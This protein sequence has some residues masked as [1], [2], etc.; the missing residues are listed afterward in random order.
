M[1]PLLRVNS[2]KLTKVNPEGSGGFPQLKRGR[3]ITSTQL[4]ERANELEEIHKRWNQI[5]INANPVISAY[6]S[7]IVPKSSRMKR[8]LRNDGGDADGSVVGAK[9]WSSNGRTKHQIVHCLTLGCLK[10]SIEEL[11]ATA[12]VLDRYANGYADSEFVR[13]VNLKNNRK[14]WD[15]LLSDENLSRTSFCQT[16]VDI[17]FIERFGVDNVAPDYDDEV[18]VTLYK[19]DLSMSELFEK[20][21]VTYTNL[22][23]LGKDTVVLS[24]G[25]YAK[26]KSCA[27]YLIAMSLVERT[28]MDN[29]ISSTSRFFGG[30]N[31]PAPSNEPVIGVID[32]LFDSDLENTYFSEWVEPHELVDPNIKR[33]KDSYLHGT[34]VDSIIVDGPALNP[35][36]DDGCGRFRVRHFGITADLRFSVLTFLREIEGIVRGNRDIKVWNLSLGSPLTISDNSISPVGAVL[37]KIQRECDVIFVIA[38]T[39]LPKKIAHGTEYK[40]GSPADSVN[41]MVVNAVDGEG[42]PASYSR[43]GPVLSSFTKPDIAYFGGDENEP[44]LTWAD[45]SEHYSCGTSYAAP[46]IARKLAYLTEIIGLSKEAAKALIIDSASRWEQQ[47]DSRLLGHGVVP[48]HIN[49]IL[50]CPDDEIRLIVSGVAGPNKTSNFD[51]PVPRSKGKH[52]Y[53]GK[54]TLCYFPN[55]TRQQ[56]VDYTNTEIDLKFGRIKDG[57]ISSINNDH[58]GEKFFYITEEEAR[59]YFQ[60]WDNTKI[61]R[62]SIKSRAIAKKSFPNSNWGFSL[63]A[64]KRLDAT[65]REELPFGLV[66]S[67]KAMDGVNRLAVFLQHCRANQ[68]NVDQID[69]AQS[70]E[71]H[72]LIEEDIHFED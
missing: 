26:L 69:I 36:R 49:E 9:Y 12:N 3:K 71:F 23:G 27:P 39:N 5:A 48:T 72:Q 29:D 68:I 64:K 57:E 44:C 16:I 70:I 6:Y 30:R 11:N 1:N 66:I 31:I 33:T 58:Q 34:C 8:L 50:Q 60:K 40:L 38:G 18:I 43:S 28:T 15:D 55:C 61:V 19:T 54:A 37:D 67:L 42:Q 4:R 63:V 21:D 53:Y 2:L 22:N 65:E 51:I 7:K 24:A 25:D 35:L 41:A 52:P 62:E 10:R 47:G 14:L 17:C 13:S 56:G 45:K 20:M 59:H 46:W 32:T